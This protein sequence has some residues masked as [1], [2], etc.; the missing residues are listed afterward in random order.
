MTAPI[1]DLLRLDGED[2][3]IGLGPHRAAITALFAIAPEGRSTACGTGW[4]ADLAIVD[5]TLRLETLHLY[6]GRVTVAT[7]RAVGLGG[8]SLAVPA[9]IATSGDVTVPAPEPGGHGGL[10][11]YRLNVP[12]LCSGPLV[13]G[14]A[15]GGGAGRLAMV[16][17][18]ER[19]LELEAGRVL[20]R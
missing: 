3:L 15:P 5:D 7:G 12:L 14:R 10:I 2:W 11:Q 17:S 1:H 18:N 6:G 13:I 4:Y 20:R 19:R 8:S 16:L 9:F